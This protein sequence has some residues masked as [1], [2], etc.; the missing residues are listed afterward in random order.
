[1]TSSGVPRPGSRVEKTY[2]LPLAS[3]GTEEAEDVKRSLTLQAR[4]PFGAAPP[5]FRAWSVQEEGTPAADGAA[6]G[7]R[8]HMP[9]FYGLTR[10]GPAES[11]GRSVGEAAPALAFTGTLTEVQERA[12]EA[13]FGRHL[14]E[15]GRGGALIS[16]PCGYGKTV[17]AVSA[18]ARLGRKACVLVHKSF[19]RDQWAAAFRAFCPAAKVGFIQGK[20]CTVEGCDVVIAM[21]MTVAK[22]GYEMGEFGTICFDE[23]HHMAA[24]V[25]NAATRCFRARYV[26]GLTATK[27]RP[28]GLTPLLHWSLGASAFHVEREAETVR[29]SIALYRGA[30]PEILSRDGKPVVSAMLNKLAA[31]PARNRFL[32]ARVVEMHLA[33]RV[34]IVLSDRIAQLRALHAMVL[35]GGRVAAADVGIFTG[36]TKEA[37][38]PAQL[39]R[40]VVFCSYGMANEGL[41]KREADTCVMATP[42]GRVTQ[43][44]GRIQRPCETKKPP[45]VLDVADDASVFVHLRWKRQR[46]YSKERYEV[47]V[48]RVGEEGQPAWFA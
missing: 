16:L 35:D 41:D 11:D 32:A 43:C 38:R 6:G 19:L 46:L 40:K 25:M 28:D 22:R 21:V 26:I 33:G 7:P 39:G 42:K 12:T 17:W 34:I 3:L 20:V 45:L 24:P 27:E 36:T 30:A 1:M 31:D 23:C 10:F 14:S 4:A 44:I 5:P 29:V 37:D 13:A 15:A 47:Q 48:V 9:R 8:L 18:I 2:S